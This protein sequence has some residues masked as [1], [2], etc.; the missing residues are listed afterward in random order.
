MQMIIAGD[1]AIPA[2]KDRKTEDEGIHAENTE[3]GSFCSHAE[4]GIF[5]YLLCEGC[6]TEECG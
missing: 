3:N 4:H 5:A 2:E 6:R 1:A